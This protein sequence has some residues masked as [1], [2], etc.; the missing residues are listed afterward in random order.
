MFP[1]SAKSP[2]PAA[3][4]R[5]SPSANN[6]NSRLFFNINI[7]LLLLIL[8]LAGN[9]NAL[10]GVTVPTG[11]SVPYAVSSVCA[12]GGGTVT[13][14]AGTFVINSTMQVCSNLTVNG[15]GPST[16]LQLPPSPNGIGMFYTGSGVV[17]VTIENL[18]MDGNTPKG[19]MLLN[20]TGGGNPYTNSGIDMF[21]YNG[22]IINT[23]LTNVEIK[24]FSQIGIIMGTAN[25]VYLT[26]VN[27]HDNNYGN[28]SHNA[29]LVACNNVVISHSYLDHAHLGDGLH[30]D[31][32]GVNTTINKS[33]FSNNHG[34]GILTQNNPNVTISN[35]RTDH[36]AN[37]GIQTNASGLYILQDEGSFNGGYGVNIPATMD[38][39]GHL[40][41]YFGNGN[42]P[43]IAYFYQVTPIN[44]TS[45]GGLDTTP[46]VYEAEGESGVLGPV[47]TADWTTAYPGFSGVGAVDFNANHLSN[48]MLTFSRV[49]APSTGS[50]PLVFR[51]SNGSSGPEMMIFTVNGVTQTPL[52][53]PVTGSYSTWNTI[54]VNASLA[55]GNNVLTIA[56][57][58]A[59]APEIDNLTVKAPSL[60]SL[61]PVTNLTATA[62][63]PY[64]INLSWTAPA[65]ASTYS[66]VRSGA[67]G[68]PIVAAHITT[69]SWS[70]TDILFGDSS[71][72]YSVYS[73]NQGVGGSAVSVTAKTPI[74]NPA[75]LQANSGQTISLNWMSA[76]G[77]ASY[78]LKRS[79]SPTGSLATIASI[80]NTT[81]LFSTNS[82]ESYTDAACTVN[83]TYYYVVSAVDINGNESTNSY[84]ASA[85]CT[86]PSSFTLSMASPTINLQPGNGTTDGLTVVGNGGF[87]GTVSFTTSTLASGINI[88][89]SP[90]TTSSSTLFVVYVQPGTHTGNYPITITG[91]SGSLSASIQVTVAVGQ[92]QTITFGSI[93]TQT[94]GT[95][96]SLTASAS[97]GLT[98]SYTAS[99]ATV[100][101]V[102]G[103]TA[104]FVGSG[105]CS[106]TASQFGNSSYTAATPVTQT[107][108]VNGESQTI[109]FGSVSTQT[110][111]TPLTLAATA[112]SSLG[113]TYTASPSTVCTVSGSTA[114]FIGS[115]S[116]S[117]TA[118]QAGN[119]TY[120]AAN[121]VTQTFNVSAK[122]QN[123]TFGSIPTQ[124]VGTPLTLTATASSSLSVTY[125]ASPST[126]CSVSGSTATFV[127]A[128][129]C[130]ITAA[131]SGNSIYSA[132]TS[133]SQTF[134]VKAAAPTQSFTLAF[135]S[136]TVTIPSGGVGATD[137]VTVVGAGG[138]N[139]AVTLSATLPGGFTDAFVPNNP[140]STNS[141]FVIVA[142]PGVVPGQYIIPIKGVS[143]SLNA[144]TNL[145]V[146]VTGTQT[147]TFGTIATQTVGTPLTLAATASSGLVVSYAA[148]P[149]TV[150][151]VSGAKVTF[152]G[153][154]TCTIIASQ[155][156]NTYYS[157]ATSVSQSFSVKATGAS[158]TLSAATGTLSQVPGAS[159]GVTDAITV[160]PANGFTGT[161][162]FTVSGIPAGVDYAFTSTSSTTGTTFVIYVP[163]GVA[164]STNNKIV[165]TGTSGA[166]T[167]QTTVT[168]NIP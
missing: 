9:A 39:N 33:E 105:S 133:V 23:Y 6:I 158:F 21:D 30:V 78:N 35:T 62:T 13:I 3:R 151:T 81:S 120:A 111:G 136:P 38:G 89:F 80:P 58:G 22:D 17:N 119:S 10:A 31:F 101:T 56:P 69:T 28:F 14:P 47:D 75:G 72:T 52:T 74:D 54:T 77:A 86:A 83:N 107:F 82:E 159:T 49:G 112:S 155:S 139:G 154:G 153:A 152:A 163:A 46:N 4:T 96:L 160:N 102:S 67:N 100:C 114:T 79:T 108:N 55:L 110:V 85:N 94:V 91:T 142:Q 84:V 118:A 11:G 36:N 135:A 44:F 117:I 73:E 137:L 162:T 57:S 40:D 29:Y 43:D 63:S 48:G 161:V 41:G 88:A 87:S 109:T 97:S 104:F 64:Q 1:Q 7:W 19:A 148:S 98:M 18:V 130:T 165:I 126:V 164:A 147:I 103:S 59:A 156:G 150:C 157:A 20:G 68:Y 146:N 113:V 116:C 93:P 141:T 42:N 128:G 90:T 34:L 76:N 65:G 53:F 99:P 167:A 66:I 121:S 127:G 2:S 95:P 51:Y 26:N 145:T 125:S 15:A 71:Y 27:L 25:G 50:F 144:T 138:F 70:D 124:T 8:G 134:T 132:A 122:T 45:N 149:S 115:G 106:I 5:V 32:G 143:G 92:S 168:L 37:D 61:G 129:S 16:I 123:I 166:T 140:T 60:S 24:N 12:S 131:Q